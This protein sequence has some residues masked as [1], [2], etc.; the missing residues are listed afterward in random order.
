MKLIFTLIYSLLSF[1]AFAQQEIRVFFEKKNNG[2]ILYADNNAFCPV[3]MLLDLKLD[4]LSFLAGEKKTIV[5]PQK[6]EKFKLGELNVLYSSMPNKFSFNYRFSLG[7][8][9]K[10]KYDEEYE[11]DLPFQ[12]IRNIIFFRDTREI[13]PTKMIMHWISRWMREQKFWLPEMEL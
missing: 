6:N 3:S 1:P 8:I 11:Y 13:S 12:K 9:N 2:Y 10:I 5:I 4:N 7:D